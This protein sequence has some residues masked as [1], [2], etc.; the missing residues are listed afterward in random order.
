[1]VFSNNSNAAL[2]LSLCLC[3][4][5]VA[6]GFNDDIAKPKWSPKF[7]YEKV[8]TIPSVLPRQRNLVIPSLP[9]VYNSPEPKK[10]VSI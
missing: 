6:V 9:V 10:Q 8:Y 5:G 4:G 2:Y 7:L 1:M 3:L